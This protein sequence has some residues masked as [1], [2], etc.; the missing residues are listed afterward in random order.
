MDKSFEIVEDLQVNF[1]LRKP[2]FLFVDSRLEFGFRLMS[3]LKAHCAN[4]V[5]RKS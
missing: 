1:Y 2:L 5:K 3:N 4:F